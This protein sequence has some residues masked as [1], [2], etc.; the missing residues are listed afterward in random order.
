MILHSAFGDVQ[1]DAAGSASSIVDAVAK[2]LGLNTLQG[3]IVEAV[4]VGLRN[5]GL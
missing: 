1:A 3:S 5:N 2:G 4:A